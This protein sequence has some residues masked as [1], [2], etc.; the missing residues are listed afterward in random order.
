MDA[1]RNRL[2]FQAE[3][4]KAKVRMSDIDEALKLTQNLSVSIK[5]MIYPGV[6]LRINSSMLAVKTTENRCRATVE[7]GEIVFQPL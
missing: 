7:K 3:I 5:R 6:R 2:K 1:L 4:K